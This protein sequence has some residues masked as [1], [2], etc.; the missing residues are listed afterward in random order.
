MLSLHMKTTVKIVTNNS[1]DYILRVL[2]RPPLFL[3]LN[4][5]EDV[6]IIIDVESEDDRLGLNM[7]P[8]KIE[9][10]EQI[11]AGD[12]IHFDELKLCVI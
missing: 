12:I 5:L 9:T 10:L 11:K 1:S 4:E 7:S 6:I 2:F 8:I 3:K